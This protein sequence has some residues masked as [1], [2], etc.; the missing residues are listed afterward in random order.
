MESIVFGIIIALAIP[1]AAIAGLII[2]Q[3]ARSQ[4]QLVK[5]RVDSLEGEIRALHGLIAGEP[6]RTQTPRP[7]V[8][9]IPPTS[10]TEG[11][12]TANA[13]PS[14]LS[15]EAPVHQQSMPAKPKGF[16]L[17]GWERQLSER[18]MVWL[19]GVALALG[20][21]FLVKFSMDQGL[22]GPAVRVTMGCLLGAGIMALGHWLSF[23][24]GA[25]NV[26]GIEPSYVPPA[27][28]GAGAAMAF[29]SL[30]AA[31]ALYDLL[32]PLAAFAGLALV[33]AAATLMSL[34]HGPF[35]AA[36]GLVAALSVP[37]LV[38]SDEPSVVGLFT[39]LLLVTAPMMALLRWR[40]W[41]W[42]AWLQL[43]GTLGWVMLWL[44]GPFRSGDEWIVGVFLLCT[45]GIFVALR[46]GIAGVSTLE[47]VIH[48]T[49]IRDVVAI[50]ATAVAL[51][52]VLLAHTADY[53]SASLALILA[54]GV[55]AL[56]FGQRDQTFD[57]VPM[58]AAG[59]SLLVLAAWNLPIANFDQA[60]L[61]H[62]TMTEGAGTYASWAGVFSV[63]FGIAGFVLCQRAE[64]PGRWAALSAGTPILVTA[65]VYWRLSSTGVELAWAAAALVLAA[66]L[67]A[68][69]QHV[70][71]FRAKP[72]MEAALGAYAVGVLAALA[73]AATM[74]LKEAWLTVALSM[75]LP[76]VAWI[77][78]RLHVLGLRRV[79]LAV[80][81][82]VLIRLT[83]NPYLLEYPIGGD[84]AFNWL[85]YGY[86]I[87]AGA[88][89]AAAYLFR[90]TGDDL[91]TQILEAG[92]ILFT[93]LLI[94][95]QI[96]HVMAGGLSVPSYGLA[97]KSLH[98]IAWLFVAAGLFAS[99]RLRD[100]QIARWAG[101]IL[102]VVAAVQ[103]VLLQA[104][105][106]NPYLTGEL[107][108]DMPILNLLLFAFALPAALFALHAYLAP[109]GS[110]RRK[111]C[112]VLALALGLLW[113]TLEVRHS[114]A[115]SQ[116][117]GSQITAAE[118]YTY[119]LAW[120]L[121]SAVVLALGIRFGSTALR[122]WGLGLLIVVVV[123]VFIIDMS[124]LDGI[125]RAFSFLGLGAA[126][127]AVGWFY[128]R[129]VGHARPEEAAG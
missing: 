71:R 108:G 106:D 89:A 87:P 34:R 60:D 121:V 115:G 107:V 23:R 12:T 27:L 51:G 19:G 111:G 45:F 73:L 129:F 79:A 120:M 53:S 50:A 11:L 54:F 90:R 85:L 21:A 29:A 63:L 61:F 46:R 69:A 38:H 5:I 118:L 35:V 24:Q 4:L 77:D 105:A 75:I 102:L 84:S 32:P 122:R 20:G 88:F 17:G 91:T 41:W 113:L 39:Y 48:E 25:V 22:L 16:G 119:S 6:R 70:A 117:S 80:A 49:K 100:H 58:I 99:P 97:E 93:V 56:A 74:A 55:A 33:A 126:L 109:D 110:W 9:Q 18:W 124:H 15:P 103:A 26:P 66:V 86:G 36:L 30:F 8:P 42:L 95:L 47:G 78:A 37:A 57:F 40:R 123:K 44:A 1:G 3:S 114:F 68:A 7:A 13:A 31:Y 62:P 81:A 10:E 125:W 82:V 14:S 2:A 96:H 128:R 65:V 59:L 101:R 64:R 104:L 127:V 72:G 76:G 116:L 94:S 92:A 52:L 83:F 43:A 28:V 67:V 98:T 112:G